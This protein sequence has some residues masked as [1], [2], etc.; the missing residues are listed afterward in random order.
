VALIEIDADGP[1]IPSLDNRA[2]SCATE[3]NAIVNL[4]R[5][6]AAHGGVEHVDLS[7]HHISRCITALA[8]SRSTNPEPEAVP[9][10]RG[11]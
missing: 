3:N 10:F 11:F 8:H 5:V 9:L 1:T 6:S 2:S 7:F 4:D